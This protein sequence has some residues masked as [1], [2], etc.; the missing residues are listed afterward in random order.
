MEKSFNYTWLA[1]MALTVLSTLC[2]YL[3]LRYT[4]LLIVGLAFLK[5]MGVAFNFMELKKAHLFWKILVLFFVAIL[6]VVIVLI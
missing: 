2:A 4:T 3:E 5:F 1:L 6:L